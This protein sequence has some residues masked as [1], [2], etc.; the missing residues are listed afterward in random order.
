MGKYDIKYACGHEGRIELFGKIADRERKI[1]YLE[2]YGDCPKCHRERQMKEIIQVEEEHNL[3]VAV[4]VSDKQE[5]YA[6]SLRASRCRR[7]LSTIN[8]FRKWFSSCDKSIDEVKE[9]STKH[10]SSELAIGYFCT[11]ETNASDIIDA[12]KYTD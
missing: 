8:Q 2:E 9:A 11:I 12:L 7:S 5:I 3:P 4:G 10:P 1:K 6:R